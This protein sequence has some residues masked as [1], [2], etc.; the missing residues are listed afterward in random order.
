MAEGENKKT[1]FDSIGER[2]E[3]SSKND[4]GSI[5]TK[6]PPTSTRQAQTESSNHRTSEVYTP[7]PKQNVGPSFRLSGAKV[8]WGVIALLVIISMFSQNNDKEKP[9]YTSNSRDVSSTTPPQSSVPATNDD[10]T[11][12]EGQYRCSRYIHNKAQELKPSLVK[13]EDI[14]RQQRIQDAESDNLNLLK[15][16]IDAT[17]IDQYSQISVNEYNA[18]ISDYNSRLEVFRINTNNLQSRIDNYNAEINA[19]NNYLMRNCKK[20][21]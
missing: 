11:I 17:D 4:V 15:T 6:S 10:D 19:Y 7:S 2:I 3:G 12:I 18:V 5:E 9:K 1:G 14:E 8:F 16:Q 21:Y 20:A 13:K